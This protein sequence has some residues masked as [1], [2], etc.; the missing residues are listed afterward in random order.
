MTEYSVI[1]LSDFK[2]DNLVK[3]IN[4]LVKLICPMNLG[5]MSDYATIFIL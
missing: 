4:Y 5:K 3:K 2:E 1:I